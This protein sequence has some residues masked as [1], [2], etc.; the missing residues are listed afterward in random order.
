MGRT[1]RLHSV[2]PARV[3]LSL[4]HPPCDDDAECDRMKD[5]IQ[6]AAAKDHPDAIWFLATRQTHPQDSEFERQILRAGQL[7]SVNAQRELGVMY[8][9][10]D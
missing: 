3:S 7:G 10:G 6:D 8:P 5:L 9:T 1:R 4:V 2:I